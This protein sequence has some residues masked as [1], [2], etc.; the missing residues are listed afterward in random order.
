MITENVF[1]LSFY[2]IPHCIT[3]W[4][5]ELCESWQRE[6]GVGDEVDGVESA[7]DVVVLTGLHATH[8]E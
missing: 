5:T 7:A 6:G 4:F 1:N 8:A 3:C 2:Y